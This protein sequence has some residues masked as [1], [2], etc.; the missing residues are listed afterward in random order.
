[1]KPETEES[2]VSDEELRKHPI[3][4]ISPPSE[5]EG[6]TTWVESEPISEKH[7]EEL[8]DA[9]R[10]LRSKNKQSNPNLSETE[11]LFDL[12]RKDENEQV[13]EW[14][15][16][17][18]ESGST[19]VEEIYTTDTTEEARILRRKNTDFYRVGKEEID[20]TNLEA[21]DKGNKVVSFKKYFITLGMAAALAMAFLPLMKDPQETQYTG[22]DFGSWADSGEMRG[23]DGGTDSDVLLDWVTQVTY[24]DKS[25][26]DAWLKTNDQEDKRIKVWINEDE[27]KIMIQRAD[28]DE[29][30]E[31]DLNSEQSAFA[32]LLKILNELKIEVE[33][34]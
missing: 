16:D 8:L 32:Q 27:G 15:E 3:S 29:P 20:E 1:M 24:S 14:N 11:Y 22:V 19:T 25:E 2:G 10:S 12:I 23:G 30:E 9:V 33:N 18:D 4:R 6:E 31:I 5:T 34:Q 7:K 26:R 21:S 17:E 28:S 13:Q